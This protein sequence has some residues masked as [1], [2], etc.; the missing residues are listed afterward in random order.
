MNVTFTFCFLFGT[1]LFYSLVRRA[2]TT[3]QAAIEAYLAEHNGL[4]SLGRRSSEVA[5]FLRLRGCAISRRA[6]LT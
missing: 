5:Q 2:S 6:S 4:A 1:E 3:P